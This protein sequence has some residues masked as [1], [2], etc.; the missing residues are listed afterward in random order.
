LRG[1]LKKEKDFGYNH[2]IYDYKVQKS[3]SNIMDTRKSMVYE[4]MSKRLVMQEEDA[5]PPVYPI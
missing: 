3:S 1:V 5:S 2:K 4:S